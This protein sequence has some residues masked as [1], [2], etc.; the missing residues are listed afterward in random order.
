M[1]KEKYGKD[2]VFDR[3]YGRSCPHV[4]LLLAVRVF[5]IWGEMLGQTQK[6]GPSKNAVGIVY[7]EGPITLGG[8]QASLFEATGRPPRSARRRRGRPDDSIKAVVLRVNS[9]GGSAV[10][11]EIILDATRA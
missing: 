3:K 4:R 10:A 8:G 11:S 7:V 1:L 2:V 5:K 9:P 6:K